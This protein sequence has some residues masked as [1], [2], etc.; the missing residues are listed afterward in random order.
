MRVTVTTLSIVACFAATPA[1]QTGKPGSGKPAI[2]ACALLTPDLVEKYDTQDPKIRKM[3]P[4]EEEAIGSH[5]SMCDD[6]GILIQVNPF[7]RHDDL[8][9]SP[10]KDWQPLAGVGDTA[11][12]HN[13]G[14]RWA[15]LMVWTGKHHFTIQLSIPN[16]AT[17]ESI[18]P[19]T[20]GLASALIAKLKSL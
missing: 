20:T 16:G 14:G 8:R 19:R 2:S 12:F 11:F 7:L 9:K 3:I 17:A 1:A 5:G 10:G 15:E 6:G 13:N 18:K 4:R